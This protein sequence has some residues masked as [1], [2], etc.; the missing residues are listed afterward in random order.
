MLCQAIGSWSRRLEEATWECVRNVSQLIYKL[1]VLGFNEL[2]PFM[3][4]GL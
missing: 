2:V 1:Y 4:Q 3:C